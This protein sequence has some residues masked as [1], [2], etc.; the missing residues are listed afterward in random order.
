MAKL[1][2]CAKIVYVSVSFYLTLPLSFS[3][4][5]SVSISISICLSVFVSL[6]LSLSVSLSLSLS[7]RV[8][9]R[10]CV[11]T[12]VEVREQH[13]GNVLSFH[14]VGPRD[15]TCIRQQVPLPAEPSLWT[16]ACSF[17]CLQKFGILKSTCKE[18]SKV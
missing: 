1:Q 12:E 9:V 6:C 5:V 2:N 15:Q 11:C 4:S 13:T 14:H 8:C 18:L 16:S 3:A 7:L 10:V 17:L